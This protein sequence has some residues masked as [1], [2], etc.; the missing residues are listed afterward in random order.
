MNSHAFDVAQIRESEPTS[1]K[2]RNK[3]NIFQDLKTPT[4]V[5]YES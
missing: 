2:L 3:I 4:K 5:C 1:V